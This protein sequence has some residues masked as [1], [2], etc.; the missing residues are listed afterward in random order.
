VIGHLHG[1]R[2]D[3]HLRAVREIVIVVERERH[4]EQL[5][6]GVG[7]FTS[8][9]RQRRDL[10]VI[11]ERPESRYVRLRGP[12]PIRTGPDDADANPLGCARAHGVD[13]LRPVGRALGHDLRVGLVLLEFLQST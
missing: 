3:V 1:D 10:E 2:D 6:S 9:G 5:A 11:R 7:R 13:P 4:T 8:A 12:S